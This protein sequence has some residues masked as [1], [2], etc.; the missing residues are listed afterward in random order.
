MSHLII[1]VVLC[2]MDALGNIGK[3][4]RETALCN[5][6]RWKPT[7]TPPPSWPP[8]LHRA[9]HPRQASSAATKNLIKHCFRHSPTPICRGMTPSEDAALIDLYLVSPIPINEH[10]PSKHSRCSCNALKQ[11]MSAPS[12]VET[13]EVSKTI[14]ASSQ[15]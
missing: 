13:Y 9:P 15:S 14:D 10:I 7:H 2:V 3:R 8:S 4:N 12:K 1:L 11:W 5:C 6:N